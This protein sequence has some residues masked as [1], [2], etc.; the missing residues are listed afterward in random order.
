MHK[1]QHGRTDTSCTLFSILPESCIGVRVGFRLEDS[2]TDVRSFP[3]QVGDYVGRFRV[4][5]RLV[6]LLLLG[7][8]RVE[9]LPLLAED[10][11]GAGQ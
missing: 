5:L 2:S 6:R 8:A 11:H 9:T 4:E 10:D 3:V 1:G 7:L